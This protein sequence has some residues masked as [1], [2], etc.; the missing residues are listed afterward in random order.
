MAVKTKMERR[1]KRGEVVSWTSNAGGNNSSRTGTVMRF[2]PAN[3]SAYSMISKKTPRG[4]IHGQDQ[5]S[6]DRY[7]VKSGDHWFLP[8]AKTLHVQ[9]VYNC[10]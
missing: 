1:L 9:C 5:S 3:T 8:R 6:I 7:L 4:N 2:V 10:C